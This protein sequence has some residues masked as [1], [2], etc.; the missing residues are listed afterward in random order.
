MHISLL[1]LPAAWIAFDQTSVGNRKSRLRRWSFFCSVVANKCV[2]AHASR[3]RK[4]IKSTYGE[5][6]SK[7]KLHLI[8][9]SAFTWFEHKNF[10][11]MQ[12][13]KWIW[14]TNQHCEAVRLRRNWIVHACPS[15]NCI[16]FVT[17]CTILQCF[18]FLPSSTR[19]Q[20]LNALSM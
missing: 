19:G 15:N 6:R 8:Y 20:T 13:S 1:E 16:F 9:H 10:D 14:V 11:S 12:H 3:S 5:S 7:G 4:I 17:I 2:E 18:S